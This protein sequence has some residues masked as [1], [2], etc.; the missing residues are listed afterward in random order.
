MASRDMGDMSSTTKFW[1]LVDTMKQIHATTGNV[2]AADVAYKHLLPLGHIYGRVTTH[3]NDSPH[4]GPENLAEG[5]GRKTV[6]LFGND[7]VEATILECNT[8]DTLIELGLTKEMITREV[9]V[10]SCLS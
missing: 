4:Q 2:E 10:A 9:C 6:F 3:A 8:F 5:H 7:A 1:K